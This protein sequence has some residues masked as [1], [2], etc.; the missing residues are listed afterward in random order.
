MNNGHT[1][2]KL[3]ILAV[4][5]LLPVVFVFGEGVP[6]ALSKRIDKVILKA[7]ARPLHSDVNTPWV[8]MHAIVAFEKDLEV[9][10]AEEGKKRNAIDYLT[11]HAK[12]EGKLIYQD[13]DGAP[14]LMTRG[15][16]DKSFLVQDHVD[17]YLFAYADAGVSLDR[18][19]LS[20]TGRKFKVRDKLTFAKKG[21][22]DD[23]ELGWTL[24]AVS[25]YV[26]FDEEWKADTGKKYRVE[27]VMRLAIG[28]DPRRET[29]GGP[30][31]LYG[32]AY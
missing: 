11:R 18:G 30:H 16:G 29:E 2:R 26:P 10:D 27:D 31:H 8:V 13:V 3:F 5:S 1:F 15:P 9:F 12:F 14:T 24:V 23:Q 6:K 17:Q 20:K 22:R 25:T 28:R 4:A 19:I 32:V 7:H 21:F